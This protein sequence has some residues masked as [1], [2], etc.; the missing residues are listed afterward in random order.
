MTF[1]ES[2]NFTL[3]YREFLSDDDL[4][5]LQC[6]LTADG[7]V[8]PVIPESGGLR[9]LRWSD[10]SRGRGKRGGCR[11]IYLFH[12][13]FHRIDLLAIY[14]KDEQ[15]DLSPEQKRALR[16]A[17]EVLKKEVRAKQ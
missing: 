16:I 11:V 12:P 9:K 13:E 17:T 1:V 2:R 3:R 8:A 5:E 14:G 15:E 4:C 6:L 7:S 10:S